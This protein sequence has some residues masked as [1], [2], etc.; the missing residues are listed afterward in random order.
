MEILDFNLEN[1]LDD[2]AAITALRA[3]DKGL[4]F[5]YSADRQVPVLLRGDPGR[6]RQVL[7]NLAGNAIKFTH[8]GEV[9]IRV[10]LVDEESGGRKNGLH[11]HAPVSEP[12]GISPLQPVLLRFAVRDTG[13]GIPESKLDLIFDKFTQADTS[14]TRKYGGTGLGLAISKQLVQMMGGDIGVVSEEGKGSEFWF[15]ARLGKQAEGLK[16]EVRTPSDFHNVKVL[17]VDDN[18]TNREILTTR[19]T[20]WGMRPDEAIDAPAAL[21]SLQQAHEKGDPF[22]IA[23]IDMQMPGMDGEALGRAIKAD[24]RLTDLRMLMLTSLGSRG[25]SRRLQNIGFSAYLN[26]PSRHQ[27]LFNVLSMLLTEPVSSSPQ[28][29]TIIT[30]HSARDLLN[31]LKKRYARVLLVEDNITNQQVALGILHKLG[32]TADAAANGAEAVHTLETVPY[33]LVLMDLQMPVMD[34]LTATRTIRRWQQETGRKLQASA[35]PIIAMTAH[36]MQG[37]REKCLEAG[38]NDYLSKPL[39]PEALKQMLEKWLPPEKESDNPPAAHGADAEK[40]KVNDKW[41]TAIGKKSRIPVWDKVGM[42]KRMMN[43]EDL[44]G[45]I[46][47]GFLDDIPRQINSLKSFLNA[48]DVPGVERQAHTIKGASANIGGERLRAVAFEMEKSAKRGDLSAASAHL[49]D[50]EEQFDS[51]KMEISNWKR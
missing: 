33:D 24:P 50:L 46:L 44:A 1:L 12:S 19:L 17:I 7:I 26:K 27:D 11:R 32:I 41:K 14:T 20:S 10:T 39:S 22:R 15:T 25:D 3:H 34:G 5:L 36:A 6:L 18:S 40:Q 43:D 35:I 31:G 49:A 47:A 42:L 28:S 30:R 21:R 38:M 37:D 23:I 2:F 45:K 9:A 51:L 16:T 4:E 48:G 8:S 29:K 13:I